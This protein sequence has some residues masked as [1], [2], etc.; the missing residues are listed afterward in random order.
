M[1]DKPRRDAVPFVESRLERQQA[2]DTVTGLA[3]AAHP[4]LPPS[5]DLWADILDRTHPPRLHARSEP[6][7]ELRCIDAD[8]HIGTQLRQLR[9]QTT[10]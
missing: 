10:T 7:V 5:P 1:T 3:D 4:A 9:D 8:E 2:K 6:E